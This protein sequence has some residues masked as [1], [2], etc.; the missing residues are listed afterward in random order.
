[1]SVRTF[2]LY[3]ITLIVLTFSLNSFS[4]ESE[5]N[6]ATEHI[7]DTPT[8]DEQNL[9]GNT[10]KTPA[11]AYYGETYV[12]DTRKILTSQVLGLANRLDSLFG[13]KRADDIRDKST[14]RV[15][16]RFFTK[17]G[18]TGGEDIQ[19]TLNLYLPNL[20]RWE[21]RIKKK[22]ADTVETAQTSSTG[23]ANNSPKEES[24]WNFNEESGIILAAPLD[25]FSRLRLRR[26]FVS[27]L[28]V[29][30]FYVQVGWS[31]RN[32]WQEVNSLTTGWSISKDLLFRFVNEV[33][34]GMTDKSLGS[35]HG[36]SLIKQ[37]SG[38]EAISANLRLN[39]VLQG[40]D[41]YSDRA[42]LF[43]VYRRLLPNG[44]IFLELN[45]EIA[46]EAGT[47]F[48]PLYNFFVKFEFVF[49]SI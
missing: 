43:S 14:L 6:T 44:W 4:Q 20:K 49:G 12:E 19:A 16:Q 36:P 26:E 40:H 25:Y 45:P 31:K 30:S 10:E 42:S 22:F 38:T 1:M 18:V 3:F 9:D 41:F 32:E 48:R 8:D 34:W 33:D 47:N 39:T 37:I 35:V 46:W 17:D 13:D 21:E 7:I 11:E 29:H 5:S 28:F 27:P 23:A 15:S 2:K 24:P